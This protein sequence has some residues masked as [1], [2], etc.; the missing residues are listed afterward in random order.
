[1]RTYLNHLSSEYL[2]YY[3]AAKLSRRIDDIDLNLEDFTQRINSDLV[4][5]VVNIASRCAGFIK[6]RFDN[7]LATTLDNLDLFNEFS[8]Q[9]EKIAKYY[10]SRDFAFAMR[11]IMAL[12]DKANQY[13]DHYK[14]WQLIKED[15]QEDKV[16]LVCSMG[17]NLFRLLTL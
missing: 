15:G 4:G 9:A 10:E 8:A 6:K 14:P 12:A 16:H 13:I 17:I 5:K 2:R 3:F 7:Q 1:A 11:E